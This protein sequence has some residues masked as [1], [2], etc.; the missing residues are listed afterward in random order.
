MLLAF[1]KPF[2]VLSQ[3]TQEHPSHRTLAEFGFPPDVY[4]IGRL[5][6][7]SEGLLLLSDE[8][9]WNDRLLNP[10]HAHP[11]T[12]HAQVDGTITDEA[13]RKLRSGIDLKDFHSLPCKA[14]RLDTDPAHPPRDPPIRVRK[15][16]PTSWLELTLTEGKNRQVRRMT[17]AVGFPTLRLIRVTIGSLKLADLNLTAGHWRELTSEEQH[18]LVHPSK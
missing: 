7:D 12:Y 17:A 2:D 18:Q 10:R 5:D 8:A 14:Q 15:N 3:F 6:R 4:A 1:Y 9:R 11:R 13:L 16:I